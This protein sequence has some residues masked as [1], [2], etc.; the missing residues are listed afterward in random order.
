MQ[1]AT[2]L[3]TIALCAT[4]RAADLFEEGKLRPMK[5]G[6]LI[7]ATD[8]VGGYPIFQDDGRWVFAAGKESTS[9]SG[10]I[11]MGW[12]LLD[13]VQGTYLLARQ[14]ITVSTSPGGMNNSWTGSPC[15][16]NHLYLR[17]L[18]RGR[19][20]NCMTIDPK[21][22]NVG[23]TPTA[24]L[25]VLLTNTG[26]NGRY[27]VLALMINADLLGIRNT[28]LSDWTTDQLKASPFRQEALNR[29]IEWAIPLQD[30]SI[31]AFDYSK[32]QDVYA[33]QPSLMSLLPVPE[34]LINKKRAISFLSAVEH[35][36]NQPGFKSIAY[37]HWEDYKGSWSFTTGRAS[38]ESADDGALLLCEDNRKK[39]RPEAPPCEVYRLKDGPR[40]FQSSSRPQVVAPVGSA[41]DVPEKLEK[42]KSLFDKRLITKDQYDSEV[43]GLLERL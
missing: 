8:T 17:D 4:A 37:S 27:Y 10:D 34:D 26:S 9:G 36:R 14:L 43:K 21:I 29:L 16:P 2:F 28:N 38:Q 12:V 13:Y 31:K 3:C 33:K 11:K 24:F 20:S 41:P 40:G 25:E 1:L 19:Q 6:T 30:G 42:L 22:V 35:L 7:T 39:N 23:T 15:S 18:G 32:P 5:A